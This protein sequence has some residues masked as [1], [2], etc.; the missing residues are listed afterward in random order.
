MSINTII[1]PKTTKFIHEGYVTCK[2]PK[3]VKNMVYKIAK[4]FRREFQYDFT[5]FHLDEK[6]MDYKAY[7]FTDYKAYHS[8]SGETGIEVIGACCFRYGKRYADVSERW[9]LQWIWLHPYFRNTGRLKEIWSKFINDFG[10]NFLPEPP[11]SH[12]MQGF[13]SKYGTD[14][15]RYCL[16]CPK[17]ATA[18]KAATSRARQ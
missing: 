14:E 11:L 13:L 18:P 17:T 5:Q 9:F 12:A 1:L 6:A 7:L 3:Y 8:I 10:N 16:E 2:S 15:Q 4:F